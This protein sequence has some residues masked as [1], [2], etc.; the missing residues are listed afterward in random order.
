MPR[1]RQARL[2]VE[3]AAEVIA[4][5][6]DLVLQRQERA[7]GIDEVDAGQVIL[8]GDL[9]RA[10]MLLHRH[11][12]I[13]AALDRRIVRDDDDFRAVHAADAGHHAGGR[14]TA[15]VH[16]VRRERR[17]LEEWSAGS[18][19]VLTRS[20]GRSLPRSVCLRRASSPP[21]SGAMRD[22]LLGARRRARA[23]RTHWCERP[24]SSDPPASEWVM[25]S[26][27]RF[28]VRSACGGFRWC[29]RRSRTAW[30][31]AAAGRR[32]SR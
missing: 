6:E 17:E 32:D 28:P 3:D 8:R 22:A 16:A 4:V 26:P 19:R 23:C 14:G 10:Q 21:P 9:L 15:V 29:P 7:A 30:R 5:R 1:G 20:R 27:R 12:K 13:S 11:R 25:Q 31:R 24:R 2:V 18:R